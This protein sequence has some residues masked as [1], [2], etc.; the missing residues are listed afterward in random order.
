MKKVR[1]LFSGIA[2][3]VLA[4]P[5][6]GCGGVSTDG[7]S[8]S[9][10]ARVAI[11]ANAVCNRDV[12]TCGDTTSTVDQCFKTMSVLRVTQECVDA[13]DAASCS[14]LK[15]DNPTFAATCFPPCSVSSTTCNADGT[16]SA[17]HADSSGNL[18]TVVVD[19]AAGCRNS[20]VSGVVG[21]WTGV[22]GKSYQGRTDSKDL[23]WCK[24]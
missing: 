14:D 10:S 6:G 13:I 23:C 18:T 16:L 1:T 8:S 9:G 21:T 19:C 17:C 20:V 11:D 4:L 5:L 24:Y 15:S 7:A 3:V 12:N 22:C 2:I